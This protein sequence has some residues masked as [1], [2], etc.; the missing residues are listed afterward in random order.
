MSNEKTS[1]FILLDDLDALLS[2]TPENWSSVLEF[3][4]AFLGVYNK[5]VARSAQ[6]GISA[7]TLAT[8][9]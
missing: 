4:T 6:R 7:P 3:R 2:V 9:A 5:A 1:Y 8:W